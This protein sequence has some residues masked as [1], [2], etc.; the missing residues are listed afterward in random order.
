MGSSLHDLATEI[1]REMYKGSLKSDDNNGE[2]NTIEN[3]AVSHT[4]VKVAHFW[5]L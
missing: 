1:V 2:Y 4:E 5:C 3:K